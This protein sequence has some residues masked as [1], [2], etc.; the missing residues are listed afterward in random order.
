LSI[1]KIRI[2][3]TEGLDFDLLDAHLICP[4][5]SPRR[6]VIPGRAKHELRC[7]SVRAA[8]VPQPAGS[9]TLSV[10]EIVITGLDPVIHLLRKNLYEDGCPGQARA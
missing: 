7:A 5:G 1:L 4:S 3:F 9:V 10:I 2:F 8:G 6:L